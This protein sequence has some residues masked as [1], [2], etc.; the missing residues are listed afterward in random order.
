MEPESD[1]FASS[2]SKEEEVELSQQP[3]SQRRTGSAPSLSRR[4]AMATARFRPLIAEEEVHNDLLMSS[5][6][7]TPTVQTVSVQAPIASPVSSPTPV[8][9]SLYVS[10]EYR[11]QAG[12]NY[13]G[14]PT[15]TCVS[16]FI[17]TTTGVARGAKIPV[18]QAYI[19]VAVRCIDLYCNYCFLFYLEQIYQ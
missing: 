14:E 16:C 2:K 11:D 9:V 18:G 13:C 19:C 3:F 4:K 12:A 10:R 1:P 17:G 15:G 5:L 7:S 8:P 6:V